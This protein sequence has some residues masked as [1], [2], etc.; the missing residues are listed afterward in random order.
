MIEGCTLLITPYAI[1]MIIFHVLLHNLIRSVLD[2]AYHQ[3]GICRMYSEENPQD[4]RL[5]VSDFYS[6][7]WIMLFLRAEISFKPYI[8]TVNADNTV[9]DLPPFKY[10]L[11]LCKYLS[12]YGKPFQI[13]PGMPEWSS[14]LSIN[15]ISLYEELFKELDHAVLEH[16]CLEYFLFLFL[17]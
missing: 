6:Q 17:L 16:P 9:I 3:Y 1:F 7:E 2:F 5:F 11:F 10:L 13:I 4:F 15:L 8:M 14:I 12:D